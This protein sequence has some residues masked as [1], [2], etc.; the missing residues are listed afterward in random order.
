MPVADHGNFDVAIEASRTLLR[1]TL[2]G[3]IATGAAPQTVD[4]NGVRALVTPQLTLND[5]MLRRT[6][7]SPPASTLPVRRSM[8]SRCR[9]CRARFRPARA[10]YRWLAR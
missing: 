7:P 6:T 2:T 1:S 8:S 3:I 4:S 5:V 9:S 10:A